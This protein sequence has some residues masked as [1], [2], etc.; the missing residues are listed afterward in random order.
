[1][2]KLTLPSVAFMICS[3]KGMLEK[4]SVLFAKSL[5]KFG[6]TLK[7]SP[8]Y[9]LAPRKGKN[10]SANTLELFNKLNVS[11]HYEHL[12]DKYETYAFANKII[13]CAYF[14]K[15]LEEDILIFCDSDQLVLGNLDELILAKEDIAMQ[16]VALKG[17]GTNGKD[18][19]ANYWE[20]LYRLTH[21]KKQSYITL[22][23]SEKILQYYNA[24]L[25]AAKRKLGLF[26]K[27]NK[28]FGLV[29]QNQL[30][31][32]KGDF[33]LEQSVLS[34]TIA[35]ME[36][37]V[38]VLPNGYNYH[39]L[40][41]TNITEAFTKIE[42]GEINLLH[43]H[44]NFEHPIQL[45]IP[46]GVPISKDNSILNWINDKLMDCG[47]NDRLFLTESEST[48][49]LKKKELQALFDKKTNT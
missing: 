9:S 18:E 41:E 12:N 5:R 10:I 16:H 24:G 36:L 28:N 31:P 34:A 40:K 33:F 13:T 14:E 37:S 45:K 22:S 27:W 38:K 17:I 49:N 35:A 29:M 47:I 1:V 43:Y 32:T 6:G 15:Q 26:E 48:F 8:I 39:L 20:E 19:N 30:K 46:K 44:T 3:E 11:H 25:I 42:Y 2:S 23:N 7:D 4:K 21:V